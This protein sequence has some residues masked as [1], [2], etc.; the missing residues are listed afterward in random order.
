VEGDP[1]D[2]FSLQAFKD[3]LGSVILAKSNPFCSKEAFYD[4]LTMLGLAGFG[5][6][7]L[8]LFT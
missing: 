7:T 4:H 6:Y 3:V 5:L 2:I 8:F 1:D